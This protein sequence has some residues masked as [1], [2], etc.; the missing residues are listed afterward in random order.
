MSDCLAYDD[1]WQQF[2]HVYIYL[3]ILKPTYGLF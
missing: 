1:H 3:Y 2:T